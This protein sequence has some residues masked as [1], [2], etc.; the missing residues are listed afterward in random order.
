MV[1]FIL[2]KNM[3]APCPCPK[4]F[5]EA[6]VKILRLIELTKEVSEKPS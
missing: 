5:P 3:A 6:K 2:V 4:S 1:L